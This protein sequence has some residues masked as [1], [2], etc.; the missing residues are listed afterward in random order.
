MAF[1]SH[2]QA[3]KLEN[4]TVKNT[5]QKLLGWSNLEYTEFQEA[6]GLEYLKIELNNDMEAVR[7][8][9]Y[10]KLFWSWWINHWISRD[11]IFI[12]EFSMLNESWVNKMY[13]NR[14]NPQSRFFKLSKK[15]MEASYATLI[16][17]LIDNSNNC[18][19]KDLC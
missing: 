12:A 17:S 3:V 8:I 5:V 4:E 6:M 14:N 10:N 15:M 7:M 1:R 18:K 16:G 2:I 9:S 13:V 19:H 11:K